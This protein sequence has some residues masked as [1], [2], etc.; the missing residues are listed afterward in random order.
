[1]NRDALA[2]RIFI[3]AIARSPSFLVSGA[4][5][6]TRTAEVSLRAAD[7]FIGELEKRR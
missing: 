5:T 2:A 4:T 3:E 7:A 6:L 1:M